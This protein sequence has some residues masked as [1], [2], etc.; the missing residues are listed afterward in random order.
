MIK[1]SVERADLLNEG[2]RLKEGSSEIRANDIQY[3][4]TTLNDN[5]ATLED[6]ITARYDDACY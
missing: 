6:T 1:M 5:W 2:H 4:L 3:K